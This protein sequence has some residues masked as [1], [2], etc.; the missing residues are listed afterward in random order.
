MWRTGLW[1]IA[2]I[3]AALAAVRL[4][5]YAVLAHFDLPQ[6]HLP[7][8]L[9]QWDCNWYLSIAQHGYDVARYD[10]GGFSRANW[11]FFPLF[12]L[13]V[14]AVTALAGTDPKVAGVLIST[15]A[16][17]A[18]A[19]LGALY[20]RISRGETSPWN[21]LLLVS[22]WP[23]SFY[24]HAQYTEALY[25]ALT[26]LVLLA[27]TENRP[28]GAGI[29]CAALTA[30]RP[31]GILLAAWIG[32]RQLRYIGS[33]N[34]PRHTLIWLL[35]TAI[36]PLGLLIFM[37]FLYLHAGD[38]L[39]FHHIQ[40]GWERQGGN[41]LT[42]LVHALSRFDPSHPHPGALYLPGW[43]ILGL[44]AAAWLLAARRFAEAWLCGM[45]VIVALASGTVFSVSRYVSASP[46][47]LFA[48]ADLMNKIRQPWLRWAI[49][50][51]MA[52]LQVFL[53]LAWYRGAD[54]LN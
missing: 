54:F 52:T 48:V 19:T 12:P 16:F 18:F 23:F 39:A 34:T 17:I 47:F 37:A 32:L 36:A 49:L 50:L 21:W 27:L 28:L 43:A 42:V 25:A 5:T 13:L 8:A 38:A 29:A 4:T 14:R 40:S 44:A 26:T 35:P 2:A 3:A 46:V 10:V 41:P 30:T 11:A 53:V 20:R 9:C 6:A 1:K 33:A 24:F 22:A 31:T 15:A 51:A 45:T 7:Q